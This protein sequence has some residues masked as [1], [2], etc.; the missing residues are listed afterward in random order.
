MIEQMLN[1]LKGAPNKGNAEGAVGIF[2]NSRRVWATAL[3][4]VPPKKRPCAT[5]AR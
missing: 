3:R 4:P 2:A 5:L 1:Y